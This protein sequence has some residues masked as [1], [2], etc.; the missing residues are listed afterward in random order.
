MGFRQAGILATVGFFLGIVFGFIW[1]PQLDHNLFV[2]VIFMCFTI[3][4]RILHV[5]ITPEAIQDATHFYTLFYNAPPAIKAFLHSMMG[6]GIICLLGKLHKWDE[7][8]IWFD[9]SSLAVFVFAVAV[10]LTVTIPALKAVVNPADA[11]PE[12]TFDQ[13]LGLLGAG[14]TIIAGLLV[15][16]LVMQ[17]RRAG[18][19]RAGKEADHFSCSGWTR[20]REARRSKGVGGRGEGKD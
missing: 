20:I 18:V 12:F 9:G 19:D 10:Y 14:N 8:A 4:Y 17:A 7:S 2:G 6:I 15:L 3:D 16:V 11:D 1:H 5:K 13:N